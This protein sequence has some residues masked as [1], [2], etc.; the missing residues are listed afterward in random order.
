MS[1]YTQFIMHRSIGRRSQNA[2]ERQTGKTGSPITPLLASAANNRDPLRQRTT[3]YHYHY[4]HCTRRPRVQG[5]MYIINMLLF[6]CQN[7][8]SAVAR[9]L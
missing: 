9:T 7:N 4:Y 1:R 5:H 3:V 2:R 8:N 6:I